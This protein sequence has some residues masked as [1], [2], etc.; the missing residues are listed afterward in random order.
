MSRPLFS[1][2]SSAAR[3]TAAVVLAAVYYGASR[4]GFLF[5]ISPGNVTAVWPPSGI[6]LAAFLLLG[7]G[8]WPGIWLGSF[9]ANSVLF[10]NE[11]SPASVAAASTL[12][13]G[14]TL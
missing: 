8:V 12:G 1:L 9:L 10:V 4:L 14:S 11:I 7:Y 5:A 3:L 13:A 6:A 2:H